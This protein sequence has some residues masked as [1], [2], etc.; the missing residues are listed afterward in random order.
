MTRVALAQA[1]A[2][3][4]HFFDFAFPHHPVVR[5]VLALQAIAVLAVFALRQRPYDFIRH[6]AVPVAKRWVELNPLAGL[7][8]RSWRLPHEETCADAVHS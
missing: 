4:D 3:S 1:R 8:N 6:R 5:L 7:E 2:A